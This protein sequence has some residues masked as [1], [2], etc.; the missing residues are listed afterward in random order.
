MNTNYT[1]SDEIKMLFKRLLPDFVFCSKE[2]FKVT[3]LALEGLE[4]NPVTIVPGGSDPFLN[5]NNFLNCP[6][7]FCFPT[8]PSWD[9]HIYSIL[10]SSGTTGLPKGTKI[11]DKSAHYII[12]R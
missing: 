6:N 8:L 12:H 5:Y 4:K 10:F 2:A 9:D 11:K 1:F 3:K 7:T